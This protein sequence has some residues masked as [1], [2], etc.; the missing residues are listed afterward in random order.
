MDFEDTPEEGAYRQEVREWL[1]R[2]T[3]RRES[4]A[5]LSA[6]APLGE[7]IAAA[8][9]FQRKKQEA[10]YAAI[11]LPRAYGGRGG[12]PIGQVIYYQEETNF[13]NFGVIETFG[14]GLGMCIPTL[15]HNGAE[16]QRQRY[17]APAI[18]GD[19]IW[20]QLFSE[21]SGGSDVAAA[22]TTAV[23]DGESWI[24]RGQ[25]TWTSGAHFSDYGLI[26]TRT[27]P[28]APKHRGMTIF[29]VDMKA[30]GVEVRPIVQMSR[31]TEFN[32]VFFDDVRVPDS[33]RIGEVNDGWNV[34]LSTLMHERAGIGGRS[35]DL[36]WR[37]LLRIGD[38]HTINGAAASADWRI[39]ERIVDAW[40]LEF[41]AQLLSFRGQTALSRGQTPGPE[42][43]IM[44]M[45]K[46]PLLQQ[47]AYLAMD[48]LGEA[49]LL[50]HADLGQDWRD[51]EKAWTFGAA[52][53]IAG[54]T[55]E[56]LRNI[57]AERVLGL[58]PEIRVDKDVPFKDV[59]V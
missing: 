11:T 40:V 32:D 30:P 2:T 42:Q 20:C 16:A 10:G 26:T 38:K 48:I 5:G 52:I 43:S 34:A 21:P 35:R 1:N 3:M 56:I 53:R 27:D 8:K 50:T 25:K 29:V 7:R 44:K 14:V 37:Q 51:V 18:R 57:V 46:A 58:P 41:G 59:L 33:Q 13:E 39:G 24:L 9:A 19:E 36:G 12:S 28:D 31:E 6:D 15:L 23:R 55:D 17:V 4:H 47:N 45:L 22:R 49:G 54:G